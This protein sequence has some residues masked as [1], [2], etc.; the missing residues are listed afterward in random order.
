M[1]KNNFLPNKESEYKLFKDSKFL[2]N[3][4]LSFEDEELN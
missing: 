4:D 2:K 3:K 1:S